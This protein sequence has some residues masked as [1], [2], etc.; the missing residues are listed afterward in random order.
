MN[1][2]DVM[3]LGLELPNVFEDYPFPDDMDS[4]T[5]KHQKN[6]KWFALIMTVN[7]KQYLNIKTDP[8]YS[9]L[10]RNTYS[11]IIPAYQMNKHHWNTSIL[12]DECD[13][14]LIK[15]LLEQSYD[16]TKK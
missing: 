13:S 12:S 8:E 11:Y 6:K 4:V 15:E 14:E 1:R 10:L 9:E 5:L 16:L 3:K 7:G 2:E